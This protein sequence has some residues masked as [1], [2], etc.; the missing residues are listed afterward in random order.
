MAH[1]QWGSTPEDD[2]QQEAKELINNLMDHCVLKPQYVMK[3]SDT[4][5]GADR[6]HPCNWAVSYFR[7]WNDFTG[8]AQ[9][10][11]VLDAS[12]D[13]ID[14]FYAHYDTGLMPHWC[15]IRRFS[16]GEEERVFCRLH[17]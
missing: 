16:H 5:G 11:K 7:V 4:W 15:K 10:L 17:L 12:L 9:W 2:Y 1:Y 6:L 3:P 8:D 13:Q 14:F